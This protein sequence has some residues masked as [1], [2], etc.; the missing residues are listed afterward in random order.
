MTTKA[1]PPC[2][3]EA[4]RSQASVSKDAPPNAESGRKPTQEEPR[5]LEE[6]ISREQIILRAVT[7]HLLP[8]AQIKMA[9]GEVETVSP[10]GNLSS[11]TKPDSECQEKTWLEVP[12][13]DVAKDQEALQNQSKKLMQLVTS[14]GTYERLAEANRLSDAKS[15]EEAVKEALDSAAAD[16]ITEIVAE[17]K[18]VLSSE[19]AN[20]ALRVKGAELLVATERALSDQKNIDKLA[21]L[22]GKGLQSL[23]EIAEKGDIKDKGGD[24]INS[25]QKVLNQIAE[26]KGLSSDELQKWTQYVTSSEKQKSSKLQDD[27]NL[28]AILGKANSLLTSPEAIKFI[29]NKKNGLSKGGETLLGKL[30]GVMKDKKSKDFIQKW[31]K[32]GLDILRTATADRVYTINQGFKFHVRSEPSMSKA[33]KNG[34]ILRSGDLTIVFLVVIHQVFT[35]SEVREDPSGKQT[36]LKLSDGR[37]WV[38]TDHPKPDDNRKLVSEINLTPEEEKELMNKEENGGSDDGSGASGASSKKAGELLRAQRR[39]KHRGKMLLD[40]TGKRYLGKSAD[41]L[42][43]HG[44]RLMKDNI[45]RNA[46][47][48]EIKDASV[49]F[50]LSYL[51]TMQVGPI[52]GEKDNVKY[53]LW[54]IDLSGFKILSEHVM[55]SFNE[56]TMELTVIATKLSCKMKRLGWQY[57]QQKF[58]YLSGKGLANA[59]TSNARFIFVVKI[60]F[61][62]PEEADRRKKEIEK[63]DK[64]R[65]EEAIA[66]KRSKGFTTATHSIIINK[67]KSPQR[68]NNNTDETRSGERK[69][70]ERKGE[71]KKRVGTVVVDTAATTAAAD[72]NNDAPQSPTQQSVITTE[73][74][75]KLILQVTLTKKKMVMTDLSLTFDTGGGAS[76]WFYNKVSAIFKESIRMYV[77]EHLN[78]SLESYSYLILDLCNKYAQ[79]YY[80]TLLDI[81]KAAKKGALESKKGASLSPQKGKDASNST[82]K[83]T[84]DTTIITTTQSEN[85]VAA[86]T[87]KTRNTVARGRTNS[88]EL[89][90]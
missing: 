1:A 36:Y 6:D 28:A 69:K 39:F 63:R 26:G 20:R 87:E 52:E 88:T 85:G 10:Q 62:K 78:K 89:T 86:E 90:L 18:T 68:T 64:Q 9:N 65:E 7:K 22:A 50:L 54:D 35:V 38:F 60:E 30:E 13:C 70:E 79:Q 43:S 41:E 58:P 83:P 82:N 16:Q 31:A 27:P 4:A 56:K 11:H 17:A 32:S 25:A 72:I 67:N 75:E 77:E 37:G 59:Y 73:D 53:K 23:S 33:S 47:L 21:D 80:L 8:G 19:E 76:T 71:E 49:E 57:K 24:I 48:T 15:I 74:K 29:K 12:E 84:D 34:I 40:I 3:P 81:V 46:F 5:G 44:G 14:L 61:I 66:K 42:L 2:P 51:P 55:V 45:A